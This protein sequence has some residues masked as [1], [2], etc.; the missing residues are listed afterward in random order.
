MARKGLKKCQ[1]CFSYK[2]RA[3]FPRNSGYAQHVCETCGSYNTQKRPHEIHPL[4]K[5]FLFGGEAC[6]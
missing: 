4:E 1:G 5:A 3:M 2:P 6:Q